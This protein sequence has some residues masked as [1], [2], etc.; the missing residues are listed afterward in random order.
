M[1]CCH[2]DSLNGTLKA[3]AQGANISIAAAKDLMTLG[4]IF[5]AG[6]TLAQPPSDKNPGFVPKWKTIDPKITPQNRILIA[7]RP[8]AGQSQAQETDKREKRAKLNAHYDGM[9]GKAETENPQQL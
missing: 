9:H 3:A 5:Q 6:T 1:A 2:T 8:V 7:L 4:R